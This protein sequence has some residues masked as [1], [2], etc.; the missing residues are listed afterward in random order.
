MID[1]MRETK[2]TL[3][4]TEPLCFQVKQEGKQKQFVDANIHR[5][6]Q[7]HSNGITNV[8]PQVML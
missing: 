2:K 6:Y 8:L 7:V 3:T 1:G 5:E 4:L